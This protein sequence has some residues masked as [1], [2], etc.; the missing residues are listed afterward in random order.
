MSKA[1][2]RIKVK[3]IKWKA[4]WEVNEGER[5]EKEGEIEVK[6]GRREHKDRRQEKVV[7][8]H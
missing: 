6:V 4:C 5:Q 7:W 2:K 3:C 1:K 8:K